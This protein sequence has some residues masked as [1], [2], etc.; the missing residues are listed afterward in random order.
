MSERVLG[1][2]VCCVS[3]VGVVRGVG[4]DGTPAL[5]IAVYYTLKYCLSMVLGLSLLV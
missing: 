4:Y 2:V 1:A 3:E 5:S